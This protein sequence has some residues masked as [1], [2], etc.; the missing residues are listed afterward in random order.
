MHSGREAD[1][2]QEVMDFFEAEDEIPDRTINKY[3]HRKIFDQTRLSRLP[4][5][6]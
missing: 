5:I 4:V 3:A 2:P 6:L 1:Q